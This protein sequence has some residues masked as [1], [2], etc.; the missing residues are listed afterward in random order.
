MTIMKF[1]KSKEEKALEQRLALRQGINELKKCDRALEKKKDEMIRHAQEAK[2]QGILQQYKIAVNGLKMVLSYQKRCKAMTLQIQMTESMRDLTTM[3]SK[4]V[5]L[6]GN[7]G[8]EVSGLTKTMNFSQ[9]QMDFEKGML[10]AEQAMSQLEDFLE[11]SGMS[12][13]LEDETELDT[14][15]E[16]MIDLTGVAEQDAVDAEIERR[17]A[18]IEAKSNKLQE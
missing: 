9:N 13:E 4:F 11:E 18:E 14:E 7:V 2:K 8:K 5:N 1:F 16:R 6:M 15:I 3:S 10:S 12:F 17:L